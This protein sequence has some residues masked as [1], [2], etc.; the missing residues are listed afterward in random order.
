MAMVKYIKLKHLRRYFIYYL[1]LVI[2]TTINSSF[3]ALPLLILLLSVPQHFL[4]LLLAHYRHHRCYCWTDDTIPKNRFYLILYKKQPT[5]RS[6]WSAIDKDQT[7]HYYTEYKIFYAFKRKY[8]K[9][10]TK[11]SLALQTMTPPIKIVML[12]LL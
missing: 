5:N 4:W 10:V 9:I 6:K 3:V 2:F 7:L 11:R 8:L 12:G 1:L